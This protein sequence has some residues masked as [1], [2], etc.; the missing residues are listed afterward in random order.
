MGGSIGSLLISIPMSVADIHHPVTG[1]PLYLWIALVSV[2]GG[3]GF[4]IAWRELNSA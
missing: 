1:L 3:A 2:G 4:S